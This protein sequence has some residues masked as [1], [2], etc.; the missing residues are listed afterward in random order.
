MENWC[1]WDL[2]W[3]QILDFFASKRG[4]GTAGVR[5]VFILL[6][7]ISMWGRKAGTTLYS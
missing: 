7:I 1:E 6:K 2:N 5:I 3:P 4:S